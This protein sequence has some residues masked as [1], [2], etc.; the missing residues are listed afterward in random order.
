MQTFHSTLWTFLLNDVSLKP[1]KLVHKPITVIT[2]DPPW[3]CD[4]RPSAPNKRILK[5]YQPYPA[6][7]AANQSKSYF[8]QAL[9]NFSSL[10]ELFVQASR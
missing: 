10:R 7:M 2:L 9:H 6:G 8:E 3:A 1:N 4:N 5:E